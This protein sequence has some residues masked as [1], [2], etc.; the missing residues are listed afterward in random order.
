M[1]NFFNTNWLVR[2]HM[3]IHELHLFLQALALAIINM[4]VEYYFNTGIGWVVYMV[5]TPVPLRESGF[6]AGR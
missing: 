4:N 5:G 6:E 3:F 2:V 1:E